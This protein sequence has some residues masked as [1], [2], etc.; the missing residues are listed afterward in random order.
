MPGDTEPSCTVKRV[1]PS[2]EEYSSPAFYLT[3]PI[4]VITENSIYINEND[5]LTG[6]DLYTT[7]AHEGYPGQLYQTVYLHL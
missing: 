1:S 4:D 2:L 3:P 6:L 5:P 7:L